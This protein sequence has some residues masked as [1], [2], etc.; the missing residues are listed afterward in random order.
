MP[1]SSKRVAGLVGPALIAITISEVVNLDIWK[2]NDARLTYLN[3][4]FL[5]VAGLGIVHAHN[6][7]VRAWPV[8]LT[9]VGWLAMAAGS[10][11]MFAPKS[12]Q[13]GENAPTYAVIAALCAVGIVLTIQA[14]RPSGEVHHHR[15]PGRGAADHR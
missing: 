12:P 10:F 4:T 7:W 1:M 13:G 14:Y 11:R 8:L 2:T 9:L 5:F 6:V 15:D 3:G